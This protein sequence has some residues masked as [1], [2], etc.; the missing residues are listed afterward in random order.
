MGKNKKEL[1][2]VSI[3]VPCYNE[4]RTIALLLK[5]IY[6]QTYPLG[7]MEVV[8][9]DSMSTDATGENIQKF[10]NE[11]SDIQIKVVDNPKR[12]IP[13]AINRAVAVAKG[14]FLVRLDAHSIPKKDYVKRSIKHLIEGKGENVGGV[15]EI[16]PGGKSWIAK[17]IAAAA[18]HPF[19]V[20]D[21]LYRFT[22]K[23]GYVDTVPFGAF[24]KKTFEE[25]GRFDETL[26]ANEDYEF[27]VRIRKNGGRIWLDPAIRCVYFARSDLKK[28]A[29]QYWR[30]GYWKWR[31][32]KR[33]PNTLR[34]R[35]VG[36]PLFVLG[37]ILLIFLSFFIKPVGTIFGLELLLYFVV[38]SF[39]SIPVV[40][41]KKELLFM[42][43]IP[44]A[45]AVMHF[46]WGAGFLFSV[47]NWKGRVQ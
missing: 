41:K 14:E 46:S 7:R 26:L 22:E 30:Y 24:R 25:V 32:L 3:I 38:L 9:S 5:A 27:N 11:H 2:T 21:A 44:V 17:S 4:E 6:S 40:L 43:G 20:G 42:V 10:I 47:I 39:A 37:N 31:M 35:Q 19:G 34:W 28:L 23:A 45:A 29:R 18:A 36:P 8:I 1:P 33:Y 12:T 13:A 16:Q 15:W